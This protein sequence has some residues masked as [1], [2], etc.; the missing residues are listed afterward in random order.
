MTSLLYFAAFLAILLGA[1]HSWL[2]EKYILVR[3][4]RRDNLPQLFGSAQ[5]TTRTL[6]FAWHVTTIAW[7]GF[8]ALLVQLGQGSL[9]ASSVAQVL[10]Y[11]FTAS[12]LLPLIITRG[13][14]WSWIVMF[15]IAGIALSAVVN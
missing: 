9:T 6:R 1:V 4:F 13:K 14:H 10:G 8:A 12:G 11:T 7:W 3:L 2:G 5:F 15:A